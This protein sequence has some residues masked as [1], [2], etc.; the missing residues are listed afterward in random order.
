MESY[1]K[2]SIRFINILGEMRKVFG[3]SYNHGSFFVPS[4]SFNKT[5]SL[6]T[7]IGTVFS[8]VSLRS[9][10]TSRDLERLSNFLEEYC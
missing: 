3:R 9:S 2:C 4:R 7:Q 8:L 1:G 5:K 10:A 6:E